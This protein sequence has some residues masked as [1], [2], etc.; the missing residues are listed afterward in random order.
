MV[1]KAGR[2]AHARAFH[3]R[4][5]PR[6][7]LEGALVL[8]LDARPFEDLER[9]GVHRLAGL[10]VERASANGTVRHGFTRAHVA[11]TDGSG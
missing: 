11:R 7:Q 9:R 4:A 10:V 2:D 8:H 1:D 3:P 5:G 6:Q